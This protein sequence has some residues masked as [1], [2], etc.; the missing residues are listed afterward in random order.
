MS[1][2]FLLV[3]HG[4]P[5]ELEE[6]HNMFQQRKNMAERKINKETNMSRFTFVVV[7]D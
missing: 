3:L 7:S 5:S 1:L 2:T 6:C 4:E